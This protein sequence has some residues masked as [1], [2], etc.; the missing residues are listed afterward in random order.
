MRTRAENWQLGFRFAIDS[1][2]RD[3]LI[4]RLNLKERSPRGVV[5]VCEECTG[6]LGVGMDYPGTPWQPVWRASNV[7]EANTGASSCPTPDLNVSAPAAH[8]FGIYF[9]YKRARYWTSTA[10]VQYQ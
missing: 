8:L 2:R 4:R 5:T 9:I 3:T 10:I 7:V 1:T 6:E